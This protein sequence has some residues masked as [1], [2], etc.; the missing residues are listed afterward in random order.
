MRLLDTVVI[1]GALNVKDRHNRKA[2]RYLDM[3]PVDNEFTI[4]ISTLMEF[5]LLMK[6]RD[7]TNDER[8]LSW[9]EISSKIPAEKIL[10]H[11]ITTFVRASELEKEGMGYFDSL[12]TALAQELNSSVVTDDKQIAKHVRTEW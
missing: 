4:P 2:S 9:I 8:R 7:Y 12:I 6:A 10:R 1:V 11:T 3:L 5:D